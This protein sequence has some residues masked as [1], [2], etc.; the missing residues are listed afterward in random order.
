MYNIQIGQETIN[1]EIINGRPMISSLDVAR[2]FGKR[3]DNFIRKIENSYSYNRMI[4]L[5]KIEAANYKDQQ[6]KF[7]KMYYLT[8]DAFSYLVM[9]LTGKEADKWKW[10]Y[11]EAFELM[12]EKLSRAQKYPP[13]IE[14]FINNS[15]QGLEEYGKLNRNG[16]LKTQ[17]V[18]GYVRANP[19]DPNNKALSDIKR[20][21]KL[22]EGGNLMPEVLE[23]VIVEKQAQLT[24]GG[25]N[26]TKTLP[27]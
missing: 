22:L 24:Q 6:G 3:H 15:V 12:A 18:R 7:R 10:A 1:F 14:L 25:Q 13:M 5:L 4:R 19:R 9:G 2:R 27:A 17:I 11:I 26:A 16:L 20:A 21:L 8:K 23:T